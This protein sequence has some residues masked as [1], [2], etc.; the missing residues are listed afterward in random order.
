MYCQQQIQLE[1]DIQLLQR[2]QLRYNNIFE[3]VFKKLNEYIDSINKGISFP[4]EQ[5]G[6]L[7]DLLDYYAGIVQLWNREYPKYEP[8]LK[9]GYDKKKIFNYFENLLA[10]NNNSKEDFEIFKKFYLLLKGEEQKLYDDKVIASYFPDS[11]KERTNEQVINDAQRMMIETDKLN[12]KNQKIEKEGF[13][14]YPVDPKI[15]HLKNY[16]N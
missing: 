4:N 8:Q 10:Q 13:K 6:V 9:K 1:V 15:A 3:R 2:R 16:Y 7:L 5:K 14:D 12:K 11:Q